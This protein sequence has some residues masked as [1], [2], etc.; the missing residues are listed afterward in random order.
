MSEVSDPK[1]ALPHEKEESSFKGTQ[2]NESQ[3][4]D[5]P[6]HTSFVNIVVCCYVVLSYDGG[7]T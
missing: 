6:R 2:V 3:S 4:V 1:T 7:L 5:I